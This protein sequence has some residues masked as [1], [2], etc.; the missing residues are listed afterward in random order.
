[1][2]ASGTGIAPMIQA[3]DKILTTEG[4]TTRV[5][6]LYASKTPHDV[7]MHTHLTRYAQNHSSRFS[8][9][10]VAAAPSLGWE[11]EIGWIDDQK[12]RQYCYPPS[13]DSITLVCGIP[14]FYEVLC[15]P[16]HMMMVPT[17]TVLGDIGYTPEM[18][19]K[20]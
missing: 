16:R 14:L 8:L 1:M 5:S 6:M 13:A 15:G 10:H 7:L 11:G 18:V 9:M 19:Y 4:D 17:G 2:L 20:F 3:L 12:I